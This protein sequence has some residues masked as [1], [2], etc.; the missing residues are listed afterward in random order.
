MGVVNCCVGIP[1]EGTSYSYYDCC[2]NLVT[3]T[4]I[5]GVPRENVLMDLNQPSSN[6]LLLA[7][8]AVYN[9]STPTPTPTQTPTPTPTEFNLSSYV[10]GCCDQKIYKLQTNQQLVIGTTFSLQPNFFCYKVIPTPNI[11]VPFEILNDNFTK[12]NASNGCGSAICQPCSE[13]PLSAN[14]ENECKVVTILDL[15]ISCNSTNP[16]IN[17]PF[18]GI[19]SVTITGGTQPYTVVWTA[20]NGN[21]YTG[22]T[23][24]GQPAGTYSVNVSDK[25]NDFTA[26]AQCTLVQPIDCSFSGGI[27]Q[28][29]TP[30]PTPTQSPTPTPTTTPTPT[31]DCI[32]PSG[33]TVTGTT[34]KSCIKINSTTPIVYNNLSASTGP[35]S[36]VY[37]VSGF[38]IYNLNGYTIS[39]AS[40]N[41]TYA[42]NGAN[43]SA[44]GTTT[45]VTNFWGGR[46]NL[47]SVWVLNNPCWPGTVSGST[48]VP[49]TLFTPPYPGTLGFCATVEVPSTKVYYVGI[50]G[51]NSTIIKI[52]S[53]TVVQQPEQISGVPPTT[54]F[55]YWHIYP[56]QLNSGT[57]IIEIQCTNVGSIGAFAAEIYD[58]TLGQLTTTTSESSLN[59]LFTTK[60]YRVGGPK[61]N[62]GFCTNIL[63]P[64]GYSYNSLTNNCEEIINIPCNKCIE[65]PSGY[66][67]VNDDCIAPPLSGT[68]GVTTSFTIGDNY[69][70]YTGEYA[71][72]GTFF[73][74]DVTNKSKPLTFKN[75]LQFNTSTS[76][77]TIPSGDVS[78]L[79]DADNWTP[80][81]FA[82]LYGYQDVNLSGNPISIVKHVTTVPW[83]SVLSYG[84]EQSVFYN[85]RFKTTSS[86][87]NQWVGFITCIDLPTTQQ[88]HF[89]AGADDVFGLKLDGD[90]LIKRLNNNNS[91]F[92]SGNL[93][94]RVGADGTYDRRDGVMREITLSWMHCIPITLNAGQHTFEFFTSDVF[95]LPT[96]A[97]FEIYTGLT[98]SQLTG[99]TNYNSL[100]AYTAFSSKEITGTTQLVVG[101]FGDSTGIFCE[102]DATLYGLCDVPYCQI[103][104][105]VTN[106]QP[107]ITP[108][109]TPSATPT[110]TPTPTATFAVPT[111]LIDWSI[112]GP[113]TGGSARIEILTGST[114]LVSHSSAG[115]GSNGT[116]NV[117]NFLPTYQ[118]KLIWQSGSFLQYQLK[119]CDLVNLTEVYYSSVSGP[120]NITY[121]LT[122]NPGDHYSVI[123]VVGPS[124]IPSCPV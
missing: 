81:Y 103:D 111:G 21:T 76:A 119:I 49:S 43:S 116:I 93:P 124:L 68:S 52:N 25:W 63:C 73:Y 37:G 97:S 51:D 109:P 98:T 42:F 85:S 16:S 46:M 47:C 84:N 19:L 95:G 90:W 28:F 114:T 117:T 62:E 14:T 101:N 57:N 61:E 71:R 92:I 87:V 96:S 123:A 82:N 121:N 50:A 18:S 11:N 102:P 41:G 22:T 55:N 40:T 53:N 113:S 24:Y 27:T 64:E 8:G 12:Y 26:Q 99:I 1:I 31:P 118:I 107:T 91:F 78:I 58:N 80:S 122:V 86:F 6:M 17:N 105:E 13:L 33:F 77:L 15:G 60:D 30:T 72:Y 5:V 29:Y 44:G 112:N 94:L 79:V 23:I 100:S 108:S 54:N 45:P 34:I 115:A 20:P 70:I 9:C 38:R 120:G 48:C 65:C 36:V 32:C 56:V 2:G 3:G 83:Q 69:V 7:E 88:I 75:N 39:G 66:T 106:C 110:P 89:I 4:S 10:S 104:F 74:E 67:L 59:I 35:S